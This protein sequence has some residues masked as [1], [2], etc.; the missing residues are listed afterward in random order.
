MTIEGGGW[1]ATKTADGGV[2]FEVDTSIYPAEAIARTAHAF[3]DRAFVMLREEGSNRTRVALRA[4]DLAADVTTLVGDF[5]NSLLDYKL[6]IEIGRDTKAIRELIVAQAFVEADL[7]D[8]E[9]SRAS[10]ED[11]PRHLRSSR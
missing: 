4:K 2:E 11:D 3:T 8:R 1:W 9:D 6:R 5:C 7:L 10:F